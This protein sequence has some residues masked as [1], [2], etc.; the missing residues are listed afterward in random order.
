MNSLRRSCY[1]AFATILSTSFLFVGLAA[2][3]PDGN[4]RKGKYSYR[5]VYKACNARGEVEST[6]PA[7]NPDSKT[8][9]QWER[10]FK[11]KDFE[12]FGC[13]KEW[14][15]LSEDELNNILA[16]LWE[17]AADSPTPAKCL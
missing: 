10:V 12:Q 4:D 5:G 14:E 15:A 7:L 8:R 2:A 17:H 6:K 3:E 16:Y 11:K 9:A 1:M 13:A